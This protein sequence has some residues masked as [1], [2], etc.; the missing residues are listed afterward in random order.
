MHVACCLLLLLV[1]Q[2]VLS[3]INHSE[4]STVFS[5]SSWYL[6]MI[7]FDIDQIFFFSLYFFFHS[8]MYSTTMSRSILFL[9]VLMIMSTSAFKLNSEVSGPQRLAKRACE[10]G[11]QNQAGCDLACYNS[12]AGVP[13][14]GV[15]H[16][17]KCY[18]GFMPR[19]VSR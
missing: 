14:L 6:K 1:I 12:N 15:C 11:C 2:G 5:Y 18:C 9:F 8:I 7:L 4:E 17:G 10:F 13:V 16:D 19:H 3:L